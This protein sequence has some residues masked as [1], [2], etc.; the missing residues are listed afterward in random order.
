M[1]SKTI[2]LAEDEV[3]IAMDIQNILSNNGFTNI[4]LFSNANALLEEALK[5]PPD[6]LITDIIF[7]KKDDGVRS[8]ETLW[9][10][11]DDI[12]VLF[13]SGNT[14][15]FSFKNFN[16]SKCSFLPKPFSESELVNQVE[17]LLKRNNVGS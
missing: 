11:Y 17:T 8:A 6:L 2:F 1:K 13:I 10:K 3:I 12:P 15:H 4:V 7:G 14:S 5:T 9:E 16:P